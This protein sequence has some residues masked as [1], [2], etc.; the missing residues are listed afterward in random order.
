MANSNVACSSTTTAKV[1][2]P[3]FRFE[4]NK[5]QYHL[6][7]MVVE[8]MDRALASDNPEEIERVIAIGKK[9]LRERNK[10]IL[11][12]EKYGWDAVHCYTAGPLASDS[13]HEKR[14]KRAIKESKSLRNEKKADASRFRARKPIRAPERPSPIWEKTSSEP[15]KAGKLG[16]RPPREN[17]GVTCFRCGKPG[18]IA[19]E[20]RS[21]NARYVVASS[22]SSGQ[23][24]SQN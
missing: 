17:R 14:I 1:V 2:E 19:R 23:D 22:T 10:H 7:R 12:A 16:I 9:V 18:H 8:H 21:T 6:K 11:L 24:I 4:G 20:S 5:K 3:E 13:E 15:F